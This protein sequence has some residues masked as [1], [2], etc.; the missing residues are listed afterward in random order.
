[1]DFLWE[2]LPASY[3]SPTLST[4]KPTADNVQGW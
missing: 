3:S 2:K 1:L 4:P